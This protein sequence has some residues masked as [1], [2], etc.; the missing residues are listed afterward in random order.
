MALLPH[1]PS[2]MLL[3]LAPPAPHMPILPPPP[4][5][6]N[7]ICVYACFTSARG[8][9]LSAQVLVRDIQELRAFRATSR[10]Q[11]M[12]ARC[13]TMSCI[14]RMLRA[15]AA[16]SDMVRLLRSGRSNNRLFHDASVK[17]GEHS[18]LRFEVVVTYFGTFGR[19]RAA[20]SC[21]RPPFRRTLFSMSRCPKQ[22]PN[23]S[24]PSAPMTGPR[25]A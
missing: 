4:L 18:R 9:P 11:H 16:R 7:R 24:L 6:L 3:R 14:E 13:A 15:V 12:P 8:M 5:H 2:M 22:K 23:W 25:M 20:I 21:G 10:V 19:P 17:D 1:Y